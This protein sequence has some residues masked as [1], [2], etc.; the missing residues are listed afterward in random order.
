MCPGYKHEFGLVFRNETQATERRARK[1]QKTVVQK[2]R[3]GRQAST[4][5]P[6][7]PAGPSSAKASDSGAVA[8]TT[9]YVNRSLQLPPE[10]QASCHFVSNFV[11]VSPQHKGPGYMNYLIPLLKANRIPEQ[12]RLAF[13]AC[14]F[15]SLGNRVGTG[16]DFEQMGMMQY[17]QALAAT[18]KVLKDP[19]E[20]LTDATLAT[21]LLLGAYEGITAKK[22][23]TMAWG[24][25]IDGA[26]QLVKARGRA[27]FKTE[28][29]VALFSTVR[30]QMIG[31]MLGNG[32]T[33]TMSAEW[34]TSGA[35]Q[36]DTAAAMHRVTIRV[37][38][39][40]AE[41]NRLLGSL[42]RTADNKQLVLDL[43]RRCQQMDQGL[44]NWFRDLPEHYRF[45]TAA[46][47][48][49]VPGGDYSK[50]E[51]YP[52]RVDLYQGMWPAYVSN[53]ARASRTLL[54]AATVRCAAWVCAPIDYRTTPEYAWAARTTQ[55]TITDLL[56]SVPFMLGWFSKR[57]H[58]LER[59]GLSSYGCGDEDA[60][61][62]LPGFVLTFPLTCIINQDFTS[63][64]QRAWVRGRMNFISQE[65]GVRSA[66]LMGQV[67]CGS[68]RA[69][70]G[71]Y[72]EM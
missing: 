60:P 10:Q 37:A 71:A 40:R 15:A 42:E 19:V 55:E 59:A 39:L 27:Q 72:R 1:S 18:H 35:C 50:A 68:P 62:S 17:T 63:D 58:L 26:V 36:D 65:L 12:L 53:F 14:S 64:S 43:M 61:K 46:W 44:A 54:A 67:S 70:R 34:W 45:K 25:H 49:N 11:M 8:T 20:S 52:G 66:Y 48:D 16:H 31:F 56:A 28:A 32:T 6:S 2:I 33:P 7:T 9:S 5:G 38:E 24:S 47:E 22:M 29:G 69:P 30:T 51:V 21:I 3:P 13:N 23:G 57:K 4:A 41:V